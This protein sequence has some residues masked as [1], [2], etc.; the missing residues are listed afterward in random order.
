MLV[1]IDTYE[2]RCQQKINHKLFFDVLLTVHFNIFILVINQLDAQ[3][4]CFTI[5]LFRR[6]YMF[7][8]H[9]LVIRRSKLHYNQRLRNTLIVKQKLCASSWL[10]TTINHKHVT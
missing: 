7:R 3:N 9:V 5:S 8:A 1:N 10:I 6:L 2:I 4:F